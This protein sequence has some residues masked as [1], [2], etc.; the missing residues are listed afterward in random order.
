MII[1]GNDFSFGVIGFFFVFLTRFY[2][3]PKAVC[4]MGI[5]KL[6]EIKEENP[7]DDRGFTL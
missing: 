3:K 4:K 5:Y 6:L 1:T 2:V 7:Y